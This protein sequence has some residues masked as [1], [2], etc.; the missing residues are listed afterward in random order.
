MKLDQKILA[1]LKKGDM[2]A[3]QIQEALPEH[4]LKSVQVTLTKT[5]G[6]HVKHYTEGLK[7]QHAAVYTLGYGID[8]PNP[9]SPRKPEYR[10]PI[11]GLT[12]WQPVRPWVTQ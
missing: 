3:R 5:S 12:V 7:G 2:T 4:N 8:A 9:K 6:L 10:F 1:L 11:Q